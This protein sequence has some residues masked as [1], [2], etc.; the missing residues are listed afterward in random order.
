MACARWPPH[1]PRGCGSIGATGL[2]ATPYYDDD[3]SNDND[4]DDNNDDYYQQNAKKQN[5]KKAE[6]SHH[7]CHPSGWL[8][9][10]L[11][12]PPGGHQAP[13]P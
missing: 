11:R 7:R 3:D 2:T 9:N 5:K 1:P 6:Q 13:R 8:R 12:G 10:P 4:D